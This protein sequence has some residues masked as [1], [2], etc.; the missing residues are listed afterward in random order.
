MFNQPFDVVVWNGKVLVPATQV[1][2]SVYFS[3]YL[4]GAEF[5]VKNEPVEEAKTS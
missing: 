1:R 5:S 2:F 3:W 4:Q